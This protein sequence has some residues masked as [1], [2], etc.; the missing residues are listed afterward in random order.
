MVNTT[1]PL[2]TR[3][4]IGRPCDVVPDQPPFTVPVVFPGE[5]G[6]L[7]SLP[8]AQ[9]SAATSTSGMAAWWVRRRTAS[10]D[11]AD[12]PVAGSVSV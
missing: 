8:P 10:R 5:V 1:L 11:T 2:L 3:K 4:S 12:L 9:A 6:S 7:L